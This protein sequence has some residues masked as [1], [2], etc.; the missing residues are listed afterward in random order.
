VKT[1]VIQFYNHERCEEVALILAGRTVIQE[2]RAQQN[3]F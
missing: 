2:N 3:N 1:D